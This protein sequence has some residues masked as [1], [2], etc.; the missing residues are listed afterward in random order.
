MPITITWNDYVNPITAFTIPNDVQASLE[1]F[2]KVATV[3]I[4]G[5]IVTA[6]DSIQDLMVAIFMTQMVSP[7]L[8]QFQTATLAA[9]QAAANTAQAALV[10]AQQNA[11]PNFAA[12]GP[13]TT[14]AIL[15][16][17]NQT[18]AHGTPADPLVVLVTDANGNPVPGT[19]V[20]FA[21]VTG[22]T[23]AV[24]SGTTGVSGQVS[25]MLTPTTGANSVTATCTGL[26]GS[27]L[28]FTVTGS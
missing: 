18:A 16:G 20:T 24:A 13:A 1:S 28:T 23:L 5:Q 10:T 17:N 21:V 11:I 12:I 15:S 27:P 9:A 26:T 6:F 8:S 22:G 25:T 2:R 19:T 4:N 7:A 14:L 3:V